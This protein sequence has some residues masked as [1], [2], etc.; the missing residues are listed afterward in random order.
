MPCGRTERSQFASEAEYEAHR[1]Q[2]MK[3][4]LGEGWTDQPLSKLVAEHPELQ[5]LTLQELIARHEGGSGS[6]SGLSRASSR[7]A[8]ILQPDDRQ[9]EP[10]RSAAD[11]LRAIEGSGRRQTAAEWLQDYLREHDGAERED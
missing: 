4:I 2:M 10:Q 6:A 1:T 3:L 9:P 11:S 5:R 8:E 7:G